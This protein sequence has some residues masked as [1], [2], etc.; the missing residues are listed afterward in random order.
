MSTLNQTKINQLLSS[1][2]HGVVFQSAWLRE[3][4]YSADLQKRY[5]TGRWLDAVGTG[6]MIRT[7]EKVDYLG[8]IYALQAQSGLM[9]HPGGRTALSL[10]GYTHYLE[11]AAKRAVV[12][13]SREDKLPAWFLKRDWGMA[14][15]Y[16]PTSF[17]PAEAGLA[18]VEIKDFSVRVSNMTRAVMECLYM[19]PKEYDLME[20]YEL[21]QGLNSLVPQQVQE[22]LEQCRSVKVNRLFLYL[23]EKAGHEWLNYIDV[24]KVDMGKGKRSIVP[25]GVYIPKYEIT[26]PKEL[27]EYGERGV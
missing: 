5:R 21:M 7:G 2:P 10:Q 6:A 16:Y 1:Q 14:I 13:G 8:A 18:E 4:G 24:K 26:V 19:A 3:H 27:A 20:C 25:H 23:A 12:F 11:L 15:N 22:L 9:V 17:L